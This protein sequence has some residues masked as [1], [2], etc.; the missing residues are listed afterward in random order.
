MQSKIV[1]RKSKILVALSGGVDSAVV[2]ALL[3]K[4]GFEVIGVHLQ[5]WSEDFR[6]G[7]EKKMP[8]NKCCS[9]AALEAARSVA[10]HLKIPFYVLN[11][12]AP[13]RAKVVE[14]FLRTYAR[15]A[16]PNPCV[17][18]NREIKFGLLLRKMRALKCDYLATGHYARIGKSGKNYFLRA[19]K[20]S[21][22]DQSYFLYH[23]GQEKLR[24]ILFPLGE[25][26]KTEVRKL[27]DKFGL[28]SVSGKKE[29]Q[30]ACFFPEHDPQNFL[31]RNLPKDALK[32]GPIE[33][34][35]GKK[36]GTHRGLPLYTIGQRRGVEL[37][38][39]PE[40]FYVVGFERKKNTL[41]VGP[42]ASVF[43]ETLKAKN[44]HF[45]AGKPPKQKFRAK[46]RIRYRMPLVPATITLNKNSAHVAFDHPVRAVTPGQTIVFHE[47]EKIIGGGTIE[48]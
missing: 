27:A 43:R 41:V 38:G 48:K 1:N 33:T 16:T 20:D 19:G 2:A 39:L 3:R 35:A 44:L 25:K 36:L 34:L 14:Y 11:F 31:V 17:V 29:S 46:V 40:P 24:H 23:L 9:L 13:F 32:P 12:R 30:G 22:K 21:E 10:S 47:R 26:T 5:F 28:K 4:Q 18:C 15:G 45:T 7:G 37:G 42:D 8:E 6:P